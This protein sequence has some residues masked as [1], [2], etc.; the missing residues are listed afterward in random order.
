[1][2]FKCAAHM[3]MPGKAVRFM[4][5][6]RALRPELKKFSR[7]MVLVHACDVPCALQPLASN[8]ARCTI[9]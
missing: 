4:A 8:A 6:K 9:M 2:P 7:A 1:M 3:D 5:V